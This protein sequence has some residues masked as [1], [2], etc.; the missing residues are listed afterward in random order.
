MKSTKKEIPPIKDE[1]VLKI[2]GALKAMRQEELGFRKLLFKF[3]RSNTDYVEHVDKHT[4]ERKLKRGYM[5]D[6]TSF[7]IA[8][9]A[10]EVVIWKESKKEICKD[11]IIKVNCSKVCQKL[12]DKYEKLHQKHSKEFWDGQKGK[13]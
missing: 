8:D 10:E 4:F 12:T 7:Q 5:K 9:L 13:V 6:L 3:V 1:T 11:C 2:S